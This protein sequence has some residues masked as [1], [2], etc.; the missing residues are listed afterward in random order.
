MASKKVAA[1]AS[2]STGAAAKPKS[3]KTDAISTAERLAEARETL[4]SEL[5]MQY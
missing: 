2:G 1:T 5:E 4:K 3:S